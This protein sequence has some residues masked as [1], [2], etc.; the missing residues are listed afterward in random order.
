MPKSKSNIKIKKI[1][2]KQQHIL[3][4]QLEY[5][6]KKYELDKY[7][8]QL[9]QERIK[10]NQLQKEM[11]SKIK[12]EEEFKK[13]EENNNIINNNSEEL[14]LKIQRSEKIREE[15]SK[16]IDELLKQYNEMIKALRN[17]PGVEIL[18]KYRELESESE[19][20]KN[21]GNIKIKIRN[22]IVILSFHF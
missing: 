21:E 1:N 9:I 11:N 22:I 2:K 12:K 13:I 15:Q 10:Q 5:N 4:Y 7:K 16:I 6:K 14:I 8:N 18:N 20:L 19:N 17:N 3:D